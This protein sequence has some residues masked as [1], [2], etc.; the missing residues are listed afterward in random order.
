MQLLT[1]GDGKEC[2]PLLDSADG[3]G[4]TID[5]SG[6][7]SE[8]FRVLDLQAANIRGIKTWVSF[9]PVLNPVAVLGAI[10]TL[11][12]VDKVKIGKL[13][14]HAPPVPIDWADFGRAAEALCQ[15]MGLDYYIKNS[16]RK[17]IGRK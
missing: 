4:V 17:E 10:K 9:E 6:G 1:K 16:L 8:T 14:Y 2:F 13:N 5:G 12:F 15:S 11:D 3:Y 7:K